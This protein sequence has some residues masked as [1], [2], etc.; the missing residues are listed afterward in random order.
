MASLAQSPGSEADL[1]SA[2]PLRRMGKPG[3]SVN[4]AVSSRAQE[5]TQS[6]HDCLDRQRKKHVSL[7]AWARPLGQSPAPPQPR[8]R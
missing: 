1:L 2:L 3:T 4:F 5:L 7:T 8:T 6:Q